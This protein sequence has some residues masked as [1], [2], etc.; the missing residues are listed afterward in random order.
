MAEPSDPHRDLAGVLHDVSNAL[1]VLLG[2]VGQA[3][4]EGASAEQVTYALSI[5]EQRARLAR[6]LARQAIGAPRIDEQRG[7]GHVARDV[8]EQ[9]R[10][11]AERRGIR[12]EIEGGDDASLVSAARDLEQVLTNLTL[13]ALAHAPSGTAVRV[14]VRSDDRGCTV[15]VSDAGPG[16][17][18]ERRESI[19]RGDSL[20]PGGI[21]VGLRHAR[22]LARAAGG[23]VALADGA[24]ST[25]SELEL[26]SLA[27]GACFRITWPRADAVPRPP[28]STARLGDLAGV[29]VLIVEDD[30]AVTGLLE[31][32][33]EARG[34][35][36]LVARTAVELAKRLAEA[37]SDPGLP[38]ID[39]A[40]IDLSPIAKD[41]AG[42]FALLRKLAPGA[43]LVLVTGNADALPS[44]VDAAAVELVRKPFE[45]REVLAVVASGVRARRSKR[46]APAEDA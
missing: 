16:V 6:D 23:D 26:G 19:F 25:D 4:E 41:V 9:L 28:V 3:R 2:W 5:V 29:R 45:V 35:E 37:A 13:N 30:D 31:A 43:L 21:G 46:A 14:V 7:V 38:P 27:G 12:L 36:V 39:A 10:L 44:G 34:A 32:A 33:L 15:G 18:R 24:P 40:L 8:A 1:T 20:R 22:A 42:A 11:E 17:P